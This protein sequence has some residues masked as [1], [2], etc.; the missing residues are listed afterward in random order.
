MRKPCVDPF[1]RE[2]VAL[3]SRQGLSRVKALLD[4]H[5]TPS[6][7]DLQAIFN[8]CS[9]PNRHRLAYTYVGVFFPAFY[10]MRSHEQYEAPLEYLLR[11]HTFELVDALAGSLGLMEAGQMI[12]G[13]AARLEADLKEEGLAKQLL[14]SVGKQK[15]QLGNLWG[16]SRVSKS[17]F[18]AMY[19]R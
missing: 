12:V 5:E 9:L 3:A 18:K 14:T 4:N 17:M 7:S 8:I 10:K 13:G 1:H 15:R 19:K 11:T 16:C 2:D 6:R